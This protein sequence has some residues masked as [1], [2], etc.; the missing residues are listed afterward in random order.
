MNATQC[1][2]DLLGPLHAAGVRFSLRGIH[3]AVDAP[4]GVLTADHISLIREHREELLDAMRLQGPCD[5][6]GSTCFRDKPIHSGRS[7]RRDCAACGKTWGF[8]VWA[9]EAKRSESMLCSRE[10]TA[11]RNAATA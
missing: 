2:L 5:S 1:T 6:C 9:S 7:M 11:P 3:L 4:P 8:P 10:H